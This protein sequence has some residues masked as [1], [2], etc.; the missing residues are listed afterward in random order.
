MPQHT[1]EVGAV[2]RRLRQLRRA[3]PAGA[4]T[5]AERDI[6][7][8]LRHLRVFRPGARIGVYLAVRGEANI[9]SSLDAARSAGATLY[10]P[11]ITSRRRSTMVFVPLAPHGGT[12]NNVF[13]IA[14]PRARAGQRQPVTH[15]DAILVPLVGFDR[16]GHRLG[17]GAGFYDRALQRRQDASRAWKRPRLIGVAFALQELPAIDAASWDVGL[18]CI[19]T[20]REIIRC[21]P[22]SSAAGAYA[23]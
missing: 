20:E 12:V 2:R 7:R 3:L 6:A 23:T 18:D 15:L 10:A 8:A 1:P 21:R 13:G 14:E 22:D 5:R 17:M 19:V 9:T 11:R 16:R 4:R